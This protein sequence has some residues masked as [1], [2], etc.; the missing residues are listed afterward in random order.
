M[1]FWNTFIR[2][3]IQSYIKLAYYNISALVALGWAGIISSVG[4]VG[5][6][7]ITLGCVGLP[8]LYAKVL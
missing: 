1:L 2:Y 6:L 4:S 8:F 7:G 3:S 5:K